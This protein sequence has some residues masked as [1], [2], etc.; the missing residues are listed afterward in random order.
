MRCTPLMSIKKNEIK[1]TTTR[2]LADYSKACLSVS[3]DRL[4]MPAA[5]V[6]R[7]DG[8]ARP[9][10][11]LLQEQLQRPLHGQPRDDR[12]L[13]DH[14]RGGE[15]LQGTPRTRRRRR[16][17]RHL[18]CS[19]AGAAAA[20]AAAVL[21]VAAVVARRRRRRHDHFLV[22]HGYDCPRLCQSNR[23]TVISSALTAPSE[24]KTTGND[25]TC[26]N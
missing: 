25:K 8:A 13:V 23:T 1:A 6:G 5:G 16:R 22:R 21:Q 4:S 12:R 3:H 24:I 20:T 7:R 18:R 19:H 14:R 15:A 10:L 2:L 26:R 9:R 17:R 11:A